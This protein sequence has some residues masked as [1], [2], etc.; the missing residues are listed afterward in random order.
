MRSD[1][2]SGIGV[3]SGS[4][5]RARPG[6]R[7]A[8]A[9]VADAMTGFRSTSTMSGRASPSRARATMRSATAPRSTGELPRTPSRIRAPRSSAS[10][11]ERRLAI[12]RRQADGDVV[13]HLRQHA[14]EPDDDRRTERRDR[15]GARRSARRRRPPSARRAGPRASSPWARPIASRSSPAAA[16]R[17]RRRGARAGRGR[18]RSCAASRPRRA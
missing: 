16:D 6:R 18:G 12:D 5:R 3:T 9:P 10:I 17:R 2:S 7:P 15:G 13:E 1:G 4:R 14:T 11:A 8:T